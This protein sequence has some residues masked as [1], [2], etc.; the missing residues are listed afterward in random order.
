MIWPSRPRQLASIGFGIGLVL[1]LAACSESY[2][3]STFNHTT[4]FNTAIDYLW[5]RLLF[6][7]SV[8]FVLVESVLLYTVVKYRRRPDSGLPQHVHG[9]FALEILWTLI[10]SVILVFIAVP[11]VRTIFRTQARAVPNALQVEVIGHQWWWEFRYPQYNIVTA[12][13]LYLPVG[14][15][16]NFALKAVDVVHS[17]WVPQLGGKRDVIPNHT[18]FL[19]YT[20]DS[21][22]NTTVFNGF[23]VEYCGAS[24]A[25]MKFRAFAVSPQE[26]E[27]WAAHQA[28][29]AVFGAVAPP[30]PPGAAP[31]GAPGTA[32][33]TPPA[34]RGASS[35]PASLSALPRRPAQGATPGGSEAGPA[36]QIAAGAAADSARTRTPPA[37]PQVTPQPSPQTTSQVGFAFPRERLPAYAV[38]TMR[39]AAAVSFPDNL[40]GDPA[41]GQQIYSSQTCI[42]CHAIAGNP[43]SR[44]VI[45][46]NLTHFGSRTTLGAASFPND[47]RHLARWIKNSRAM[48]P[49]SQMPTLGRGQYDPYTKATLTAGLDDQQIADIVAYL[50]ALK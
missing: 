50:Q 21:T 19:W 47:T 42:G 29:P 40:V 44:G 31:P 13:E 4:E 10:P 38:P 43:M 1:A 14:R 33:G 7:G 30:S 23:C 32:P 22:M 12:N 5:D 34:P 28:R 27:S 9:N 36:A 24:H 16:V 18:N 48:K 3:N 49:G 39:A 20:I 15:T 8:V 25:N 35:G 37:A 11:T 17:F 41:R 26:F 6:W 46:P 2:P 45:G